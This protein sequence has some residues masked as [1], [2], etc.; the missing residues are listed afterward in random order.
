MSHSDD[1]LR[2][3]SRLWT[4][5][6]VLQTQCPVPTEPGVYGWFFRAI[7]P[8]VPTEGCVVVDGKTLLYVGICPS[9]GKPRKTPRHLRS[10][11]RGEHFK[12]NAFGSTLRKTLGILLADELGFRLKRIESK[13]DP[14]K[15]KDLR[16]TLTNKGEQALDR[17]MAENTFVTW[18]VDPTPW[19][20]ELRLLREFRLPLNIDDNAHPF[21][22]RLSVIRAEAVQRARREPP[23]QD[24]SPR[25]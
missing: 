16:E 21:A 18:Q 6:E 3:P 17:W 10:R 25:S 2:S 23:V 24:N 9:N 7:P 22:A 19:V 5:A 4:R 8:G 1:W 14:G 15:T 11:V 20:T 12:S 13:K